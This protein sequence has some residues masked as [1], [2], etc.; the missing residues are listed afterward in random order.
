MLYPSMTPSRFVSDLSGI[1]DFATSQSL[2][3]VQGNKKESSPA[4]ASRN[5]RHIISGRDG[6]RF[7]ILSIKIK[8]RQEESM[9]RNVDIDKISDGKRYGANDMVKVGCDDCR[10]CS[11]CCRGMGDSIV[12]DPMDLYRLER[13]LGK[14]ME[15]ILTAGYISLR[16]VDGVILPHL[17]MTEQSDQCSFLN[18][19][20]RCSI[21]DARPGFCR[22]FPLGRLYE[23]GT[24]SYFLQ[25]SECPKENKTKVKVRRWLDTP[26][27]G[28]Y[29]A[30]TNE[31][32]YYLKEKQNEARR[33]EDD[34]LRQQISM[35][36]L[37]LFYL[38]P[39]DTKTD[40]YAQFAARM[41]ASGKN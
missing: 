22:M 8:N 24:F 28:K 1:W 15:E 32:H 10:G 16:V 34:A 11:A 6:I 4:T 20:G 14:T 9:E 12:L 25:V 40:F 36:I 2:L 27:L 37:K 41:E 26:E 35:G 5:W 38:L 21:H 13:K 3:R 19:E 23:N 18:D 30:F 33:T 17:K 29:E 7:R 39:Y 31:W